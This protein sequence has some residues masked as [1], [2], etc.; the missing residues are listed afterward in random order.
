MF[1]KWTDNLLLIILIT[2]SACVVIEAIKTMKEVAR[3]IH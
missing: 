1:D 2:I 3:V